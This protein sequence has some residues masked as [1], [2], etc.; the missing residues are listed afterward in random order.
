[1]KAQ[2]L[3]VQ[4]LLL[5]SEVEKL[6]R[7]IAEGTRTLKSLESRILAYEDQILTLGCLEIWGFG[8]DQFLL[9][10]KIIERKSEK[11]KISLIE[12]AN[13]FFNYIRL[14]N[15]VF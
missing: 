13:E 7:K 14:E 11:Q 15:L 8:Y 9:I 10:R 12:A 4:N 1:L 2:S 6:E 3:P 5:Q